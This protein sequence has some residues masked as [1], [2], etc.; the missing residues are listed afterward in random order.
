M[1]DFVT[2]PLLYGFDEELAGTLELLF[3][4]SE[5]ETADDEFSPPFPPE[6]SSDELPETLDVLEELDELDEL[7]DKLDEPELIC[8]GSPPELQ[9][10]S[11]TVINAARITDSCFL[12]MSPLLRYPFQ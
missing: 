1:V 11:R 9:P 7:L 8:S 5:D 3:P 12:M 4:G 10:L 2:I 6:T